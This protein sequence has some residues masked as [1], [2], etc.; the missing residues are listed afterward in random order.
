MKKPSTAFA[1]T[2]FVALLFFFNSA[3]SQNIMQQKK[4]TPVSLYKHVKKSTVFMLNKSLTKSVVQNKQPQIELSFEFELKTWVLEL[5]EHNVF[6]KGFFVKDGNNKTVPYNTNT[7]RHFKGK[8]K[9]D[10][11]SVVAVNI[12]EDEMNAIVADK[13]GQIN[14]GPLNNSNGDMVIFRESDVLTIP[15]FNCEAIPVEGTENPLPNIQFP[16]SITSTI[17]AEALDIYFEAD[18]SCYTGKGSNLTATINWVTDLANN[19]SILYENDSINLTMSALKVWTVN[20]PYAGYS[21]TATILPAFGT[22]M[23]NGFPGDLAHLLS[24]RGLGGG[25]AYLNI[26]CSGA[27][28]RTGVS[29]NLGNNITPLPTYSWNSM[30]ITHE[31]GHNIA[32]NHTQ[33]CGWPGGAIDNCYTTEGGCAAGP[34]PVNGGTIMSYCHLNVGINLANGFGPL[35]G[36]AVRNAV[37]NNNCIFPKINFSRTSEIVAEESANIDNDCMDYTLLNLRMAASYAP[38]GPVQ[39]E[40]LPIAITP[41]LTIGNGKDIELVTPINF[42]LTDTISQEIQLRV[43]NDAIVEN[44]E[45]FR[46]D[47]NL[48]PNGSNAKKGNIYNLTITSADHRPDS[49]VN[50]IAYF[51]DFENATAPGTWTPAVVYGNASPNRWMIGNSGQPDFPN[52]AAYVSNNNSTAAYSGSVLA[53]SSVLW[54]VSP[55]INTTGFTNLRVSFA[56]KCLGEG[57]GIGGTGQGYTPADFGAV[58]YS[59]TG[60]NAWILVRENI[61]GRSA[62]NTEEIVLPAS[63]NNNPNVKLAFEWRNNSSVVNN[64]PFIIDSITVKGAGPGQIQSEAH[65]SNKDEAYLG[66]NATVHY[67]NHSTGKIMASIKNLSAFDYGCTSVELVRTGTGA[68]ASWG[69]DNFE[70][71]TDKAFRITTANNNAT[72]NYELSLYVT[73]QEL[74]GWAAATGNNPL[75]LR[76]IQSYD[77]ITL[78]SPPNGPNFGNNIASNTFGLNGDRIIKASFIHNEWYSLGSLNISTVCN[79]TLKQF[80]ADIVGTAYQWQVDSGSGYTNIADNTIYSGTNTATLSLNNAPTNWYGYQYRCIVTTMGGPQTG[81]AKELKFSAVWKGGISSAWSLADNWECGT[82]PDAN[83][84]VYIPNAVNHFPVLSSNATVRTLTVLNSASVTANNGAQLTIVK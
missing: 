43:F 56:A 69:L 68:T 51:E 59:G 7:G 41:T 57:S 77:D 13:N 75:D 55:T 35:P 72:A 14:I 9:G 79:N 37:R 58:Y 76:V 8:I 12:Y 47:Y 26:L 31:L 19:V 84:D 5:T 24:R 63:A 22:A 49:T 73:S 23:T 83:T 45:S 54:M 1:A 4:E 36:A 15:A 29:G 34:A 16:E 39:I 30:V 60:G 52:K 2:L 70:K 62:R 71:L 67:Y 28:V 42:T 50:Q 3:I 33:W 82:V 48:T 44:N 46:L 74:A 6:S 10:E 32:S 61:W 17:N 21:T 53:D 66:P 18:Y 78:Q 25:R 64:P 80:A 27:S 11:K 81:T 65:L 20:D 40:L 38:T